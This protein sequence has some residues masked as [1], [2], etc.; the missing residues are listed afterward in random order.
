MR[1]TTPAALCLLVA[2][3]SNAHHAP[4]ETSDEIAATLPT[5]AS[6]E[7]TIAIDQLAEL[8]KFASDASQ[9]ALS[10]SYKQKR[11][12]CTPSNLSIRREWYPIHLCHR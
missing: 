2:G 4:Q 11:G 6:T 10:S 7:A 8:A 3:F 9:D 1:F 12:L 5:V